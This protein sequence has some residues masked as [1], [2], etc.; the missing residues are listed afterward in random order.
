M[1]DLAD[2][3]V[4][5]AWYPIGSPVDIRRRGIARTRLLERPID[6]EVHRTWISPSVGG[7]ALPVTE[8]LGLVWTTLG[9]P[10]GP[11]QQMIEY[12]EVDRTTV[13][14]SSAPMGLSGPGVV[15]AAI[16]LLAGSTAP[17]AD[18]SRQAPAG[19]PAVDRDEWGALRIASGRA[20]LGALGTGVACEARIVTPYA[21][22]FAFRHPSR[23]PGQDHRPDLFAV[24]CQPLEPGLT[25]AHRLA[26]VVDLPS[27]EIERIRSGR[28]LAPDRDPATGSQAGGAR[29]DDPTDAV[30]AY[31]R[32]VDEVG[33]G[34]SAAR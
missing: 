27:V 19:G 18:G 5:N 4:E 24:F 21:A 23:P 34:A 13:N 10:N 22:V 8:R 26:A 2:G 6:L 1:S 3:V 30:R 20:D 33:S 32:W 15:E 28:P 7:H 17:D 9:R 16:E 12:Y 14:V 29:A 25:V 11:P 31:R